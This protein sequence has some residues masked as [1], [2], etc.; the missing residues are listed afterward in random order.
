MLCL[1]MNHGHAAAS[2]HE[3]DR[4][5]GLANEGDPGAQVAYGILHETG[6]GVPQ[7]ATEASKWYRRAAEQGDAEGCFRLGWLYARGDGLP[8]NLEQAAH[9]YELAAKKDHAIAQ[10]SLGWLY[11]NGD[12]VTRDIPQAITWFK[13]VADRGD[14]NAQYTLGVIH[15]GAYE[16]VP[17]NLPEAAR[18]FRLA[19]QQGVASA[20]S[21]LGAMYAQGDGVKPDPAAAY[22]WLG[23][24]LTQ[25]PEGT[26]RDDGEAVHASV[27]AKLTTGK[28]AELLELIAAWKPGSPGP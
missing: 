26:Q 28:R 27:A 24:A 9:W 11:L 14:A 21:R 13:R 23:L 12:G 25:L 6:D 16:G 1:G 3:I 15:A 8:Q 17:K 4:A 7:N 2:Q 20:Q 5:A 22:F 19:A 10:L 18:W